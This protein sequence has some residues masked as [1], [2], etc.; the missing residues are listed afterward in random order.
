MTAHNGPQNVY[1]EMS[2]NYLD[3][4]RAMELP[5]QHGYTLLDR[6]TLYVHQKIFSCSNA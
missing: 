4:S 5:S 1:D 6:V 2:L 3:L